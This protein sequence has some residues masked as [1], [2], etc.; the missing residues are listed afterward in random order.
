MNYKLKRLHEKIKK[1]FNGVYNFEATWRVL[2]GK[3]ITISYNGGYGDLFTIDFKDNDMRIDL[4]TPSSVMDF[5]INNIPDDY[6]KR[7]DLFPLLNI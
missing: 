5:I 3:Y 6:T 4:K 7:L 1:E 2:K